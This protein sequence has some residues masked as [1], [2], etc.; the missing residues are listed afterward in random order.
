MPSSSNNPSDG[1]SQGLIGR[2]LLGLVLLNAGLLFVGKQTGMFDHVGE[3]AKPRTTA[4]PRTPPAWREEL[5][6]AF[7]AF[8]AFDGDIHRTRLGQRVTPDL[9]RSNELWIGCLDDEPGVLLYLSTQAVDG[10]TLRVGASAFEAPA[11]RTYG[12]Y[13]K[14]EHTYPGLADVGGFFEALRGSTDVAVRWDVPQ[15]DV[16]GRRAFDAATLTAHFDLTGWE[17]IV[18]RAA[19]QCD[20][21]P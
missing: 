14:G 20:G 17:G 3:D 16:D 5:G 12:P 13:G 9:T 4:L 21:W 10:F 1:P 2:L 11:T 18:E 15:Q 19:T 7:G 6:D 8:A